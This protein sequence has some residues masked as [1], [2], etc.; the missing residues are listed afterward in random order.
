MSI[1]H[2]LVG[3]RWN[4]RTTKK[5]KK[6]SVRD[7]GRRIQLGSRQGRVG[8]SSD[9]CRCSPPPP[10][11]T[12]QQRSLTAGNRRRCR[13]S[14]R[15]RRRRHYSCSAVHPAHRRIVIIL[16]APVVRRRLLQCSP[17][18]NRSSLVKRSS[19]SVD[20]SCVPGL[21]RTISATNKI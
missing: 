18:T 6:N 14:D 9:D 20:Q 21:G 3:I 12:H 17:L 4:S 11:N 15:C 13:R 7:A 10:F 8:G 1:L 19:D 16:L 2:K 5:K